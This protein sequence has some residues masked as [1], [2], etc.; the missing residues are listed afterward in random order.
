MNW[1]P[2]RLSSDNS[3]FVLS[4]ALIAI[5]LAIGTE[6][7]EVQYLLKYAGQA[8]LY[9]RRRRDVIIWFG[10][11]KSMDLDEVDEKLKERGYT[12]LVKSM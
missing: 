10:F 3:G 9:V 7:K 5:C 2:V 11:M 4:D 6:L 12:P 1:V 8:P